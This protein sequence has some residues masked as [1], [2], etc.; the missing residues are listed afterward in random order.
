MVDLVSQYNRWKDE[1]DQAINNVIQSGSFING[2]AVKTFAHNLAAY[3]NTPHL[4]PCGN[5]TDA[6]MIA[7][8]R[9]GLKP[10]DEVIIPAFTYAAAVEAAILLGLT[11]VLA[12]V[13][14]HTYNI[15]P[16]S[17]DNAISTRTR[18]I[19]VVHLFGQ[20]CD[21][22]PILDISRRKN[23][24]LIEDNAQSLGAKYTF[25][26]GTVKPA[27]TMGHVG[28]YS[29]FPTKTL[30]CFGDGGALSTSDP[31]LAES[32]RMTTIHGQNKKYHHEII[33]LNSRL[34]TIQAAILNIKLRHIDEAIN[35]RQAAAAFYDNALGSIGSNII[36]PRRTPRSNH[37][38]NQYTI[39]VTNGKRDLLRAE[40]QN[41]PLPIPTTV[42]YPLSIDRQ[43]AFAGHIRI[44]VPIDNSRLLAD[45]VLSLPMHTE[46]TVHQLQYISDAIRSKA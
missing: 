34:D 44:P 36:L 9:S 15:S 10:G 4:I 43:K 38:F 24:F 26:D 39:R 46:M 1:I 40:L 20:T 33:G 25:P 30:G 14:P 32:L 37:I 21:M 7:L 12:D 28:T 5:G 8:M 22:L 19:I 35:A 6:L 23:L 17:V 27:G 2:D 18:A 31:L 42:Y 29:F 13:D 16:E 41:L 11:P 3:L 45:Q